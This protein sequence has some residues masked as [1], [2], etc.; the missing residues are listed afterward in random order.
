MNLGQFVKSPLEPIKNFTERFLMLVREYDV[1]MA[2][3][4]EKRE[5][6]IG[7]FYYSDRLTV[8]RFR[9]DFCKESYDSEY[10]QYDVYTPVGSMS[11]SEE[12][13]ALQYL[14]REY[15]TY[16]KPL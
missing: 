10:F 4:L 12:R 13:D 14:A 6:Q 8:G 7:L 9:V 11:F 3:A 5:V 15:V 16:H 1:S 2:E